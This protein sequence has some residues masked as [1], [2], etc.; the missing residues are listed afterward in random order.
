MSN[1]TQ[2]VNIGQDLNLTANSFRKRNKEK[3]KTGEY[4]ELS[5]DKADV[6]FVHSSNECYIL[7]TCEDK[8]LNY[9]RFFPFDFR[10]VFSS[11]IILANHIFYMYKKKTL[12]C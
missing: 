3:I 4:F 11:S 9:T 7:C 8:V 1:V 12:D 2:Q 5:V 6:E 10:Q